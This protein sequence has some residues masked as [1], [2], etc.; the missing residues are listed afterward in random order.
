[1]KKLAEQRK[2]YNRYLKVLRNKHA[3]TMAEILI[4][5]TIIGVI[6]AITL[7][8]LRASINESTW[9]TQRKALYTRMSQAMSMM[10]SLTVTV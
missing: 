1:M 5:L 3:F 4:S 6:A 10:G 9:N 7:P 8:A 2:F